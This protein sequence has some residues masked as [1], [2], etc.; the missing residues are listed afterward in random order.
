M[1]CGR[2]GY[3]HHYG[4]PYEDDDAYEEPYEPYDPV[5]AYFEYVLADL[6]ELLQ[7]IGIPPPPPPP[8]PTSSDAVDTRTRVDKLMAMARQDA[9]PME[10]DIAIEKLKQMGRWPS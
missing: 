5:D 3:V 1:K 6:R 7:A 4:C 9:S 8:P 10:R 2:C